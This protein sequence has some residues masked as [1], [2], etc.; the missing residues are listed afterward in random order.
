MNRRH[1]DPEMDCIASFLA[2]FLLM[3]VIAVAYI[4]LVLV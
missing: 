1:D 2:G 3:G 4:K